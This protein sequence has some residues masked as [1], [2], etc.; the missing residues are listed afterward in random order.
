MVSGTI[1]SGQIHIR[2]DDAHPISYRCS[3][4]RVAEDML[5]SL[6]NTGNSG[7]SIRVETDEQIP[8]LS[9]RSV[10]SGRSGMVS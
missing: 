2:L 3:H 9:G 7:M 6:E 8:T 5:D 1:I 4:F 10:P